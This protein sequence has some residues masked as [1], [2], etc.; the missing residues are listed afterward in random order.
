MDGFNRH[1][2]CFFSFSRCG[3]WGETNAQSTN[4]SPKITPC[5]GGLLTFFTTGGPQGW[6]LHVWSKGAPICERHI[7][8]VNNSCY[9]EFHRIFLV[10]SFMKFVDMFSDFWGNLHVLFSDTCGNKVCFFDQPSLRYPYKIHTTTVAFQVRVIEL[11]NQTDMGELMIC[12]MMAIF[13]DC[14]NRMWKNLPKCDRSWFMIYCI[15]LLIDV[16][17][18]NEFK[19]VRVLRIQLCVSDYSLY[20][21]SIHPGNVFRYVGLSSIL[22]YLC[23]LYI[24]TVYILYIYCLYT[25][26]I[27][28]NVCYFPAV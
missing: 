27:Y 20:I 9:H 12:G 24:Y 25:V 13:D 18:G 11:L 3:G 21:W 17:W 5:L 26:Y 1:F 14:D 6:S 4:F 8:P 22:C 16:Q 10:E 15:C 2:V 28:I 23:V 19:K 7:L